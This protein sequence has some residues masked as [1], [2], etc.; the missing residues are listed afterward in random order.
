M[1]ITIAII[2]VV[3]AM[4]LLIII[5]MYTDYTARRE[6]DLRLISSRTNNIIGE[7]EE[8]LLNQAQISF[9][10][11]TLLVLHY[12]IIRA[13]K[14]RSQVVS[15]KEFELIAERISNEE[16]TVSELATQRMTIQPFRA[17]ENDYQAIIQ[18][19]TLRRLRNILKAEI[20]AGIPV[21]VTD[22]QREDRRLY[23]MVLRVNISNLVQRVTE[24]KRLRQNGS[25]RQLIA[26]GLDVI[27]KAGLKDNW[28]NEKAEY[29]NNLRQTIELE[30]RRGNTGKD[31]KSAALKQKKDDLDALFGDKKKW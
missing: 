23:L 21:N 11:T 20:H 13:L 3:L 16:R 17:P 30:A 14:R 10:Q 31:G 29:L 27:N 18:L 6:Q 1:L 7:C 8:L 12:R 15:K 22:M 28:L 24:M 26:K 9:S 5:N 19:R 4:F 25:C 2:F